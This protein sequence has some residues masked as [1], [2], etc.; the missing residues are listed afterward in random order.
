VLF[1][2]CLSVS[3]VC[4]QVRKKNNRFVNVRDLSHP[5]L[6]PPPKIF[7]ILGNGKVFFFKWLTVYSEKRNSFLFKPSNKL[8]NGKKLIKSSLFF[9]PVFWIKKEIQS[10]KRKEFLFSE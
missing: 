6:L 9:P 5:L 8:V 1:L 10:L 7:S 3:T 4:G 2:F